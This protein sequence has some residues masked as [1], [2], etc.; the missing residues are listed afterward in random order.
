MAEVSD[1]VE[2]IGFNKP[3]TFYSVWS[4]CIDFCFYYVIL[5]LPYLRARVL[6]SN[7]NL[8]LSISPLQK[9]DDKKR[10]QSGIVIHGPSNWH[11]NPASF[12]GCFVTIFGSE[13]SWGAFLSSAGRGIVIS[14]TRLPFVYSRSCQDKILFGYNLKKAWQWRIWMQCNI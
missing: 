11:E 13:V 2:V 4:C 1:F 6:K 8:M 10:I 3:V 7:W 12:V 9:T 5:I 14:F